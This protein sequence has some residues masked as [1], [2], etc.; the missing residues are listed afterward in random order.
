MV[1]LTRALWVWFT[2]VCWLGWLRT[3]GWIVLLVL[4]YGACGVVLISWWLHDLLFAGLMLY[5]SCL[6]W[7]FV[8][9]LVGLVIAYS[10][11][12]VW[13]FRLLFIRCLGVAAIAILFWRAS[14]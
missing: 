13:L 8:L 5:D 14:G 2:L 6:F 3:A 4:V 7:L 11:L 12:F 1:G 10:C 9:V